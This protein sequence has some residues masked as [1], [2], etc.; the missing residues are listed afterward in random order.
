MNVSSYAFNFSDKSGIEIINR[1]SRVDQLTSQSTDGR[2]DRIDH[3][4]E[5]TEQ[6]IEVKLRFQRQYN[7][8]IQL[9]FDEL[10]LFSWSNLLSLCDIKRYCIRRIDENAHCPSNL[11]G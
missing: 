7:S 6:P 5:A 2:N 3:I 11:I 10:S 8:I 4:N 1:A 9:C